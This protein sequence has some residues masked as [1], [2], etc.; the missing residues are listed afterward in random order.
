[1]VIGTLRFGLS[2]LRI[3]H[4]SVGQFHCAAFNGS[5]FGRL[6]KAG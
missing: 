3:T 6:Q 2:N 5:R 4:S 1:V